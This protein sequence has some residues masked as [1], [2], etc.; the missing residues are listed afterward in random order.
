MAKQPIE[1]FKVAKQAEHAGIYR[2]DDGY[3]ALVLLR[4]AEKAEREQAEK[5]EAV[6]DLANYLESHDLI[7]CA[8]EFYEQAVSD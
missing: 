4:M 6:Y 3:G 2:R 8:E 7:A 5:D 1:A